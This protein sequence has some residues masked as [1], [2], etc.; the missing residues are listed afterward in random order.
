MKMWGGRVSRATPKWTTVCPIIIL[1]Q[2]IEL[3]GVGRGLLG[4]ARGGIL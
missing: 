1:V 3:L 4:D 2:E